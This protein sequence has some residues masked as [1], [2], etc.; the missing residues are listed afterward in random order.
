M[1]DREHA[2][3]IT[4]EWLDAWK[5]TTRNGS[6]NTSTTSSSSAHPWRRDGAR[7]RKAPCGARTTSCP[8]TGTDSRVLRGF[9]SHSSRF[10]GESTK[11]R[12]C[13]APIRTR[14]L[15]NPC[16]S[17]MTGSCTK[18]GSAAANERDDPDRLPAKRPVPRRPRQGFQTAMISPHDGGGS[19]SGASTDLR[20]AGV[21]ISKSWSTSSPVKSA[22]TAPAC[23]VR[24]SNSSIWSLSR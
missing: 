20:R 13:I 6:S 17:A 3:T 5:H 7:T 10:A 21:S 22:R 11:S 24:M 8:T 23:C 16:G 15:W 14:W 1:I 18:F 12:S 2:A 19:L 4:A 9:G